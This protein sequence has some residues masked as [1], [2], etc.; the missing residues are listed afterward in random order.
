[1]LTFFH[2]TPMGFSFQWNDALATLD[3]DIVASRYAT[4]AG[5]LLYQATSVH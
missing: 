5:K 4:D 3:P 2:A 1:M